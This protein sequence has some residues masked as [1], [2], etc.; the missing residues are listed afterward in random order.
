MSPTTQAD[1]RPADQPAADTALQ[2]APLGGSPVPL[3]PVFSATPAPAPAGSPEADGKPAAPEE[4]GETEMEP[5]RNGAGHTSETE[6]SDS[7]AAPG[8]KENSTGAPQDIEGEGRAQKQRF[9]RCGTV[10]L[11][12]VC[13]QLTCLSSLLLSP[14]L[15]RG[16]LPQ[17]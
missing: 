13:S 9:C 14:C 10:V 4:N 1:F 16:S 15:K 12:F 11:I 5:M 3:L 7:G 2:S 8:D 17:T 6:S